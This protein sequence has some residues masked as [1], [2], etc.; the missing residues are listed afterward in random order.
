MNFKIR[1]L[2]DDIIALINRSDVLI[3][4]KRLVLESVLNK[5]DMEATKE[6]TRE[7]AQAKIKDVP[8][9]GSKS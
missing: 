3:E 5:V 9:D 7:I 2:E 1:K 6:I 8:E 4:A